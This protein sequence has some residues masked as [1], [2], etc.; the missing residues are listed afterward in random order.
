MIGALVF[1]AIMVAVNG[2]LAFGAYRHNR[3]FDQRRRGVPR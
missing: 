1:L 2:G 3:K